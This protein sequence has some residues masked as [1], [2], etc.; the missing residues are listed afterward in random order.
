VSVLLTS[1]FL[2]LGIVV[3][4]WWAVALPLA[5][6]PLYYL[7][8]HLAGPGLE[9]DWW[10]GFLVV[11]ATSAALAA[12]GV[13]FRRLGWGHRGRRGAAGEGTAPR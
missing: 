2:A 3:G 13:L 11:T 8:L 7:G 10:L 12:L 5:V 1:A 9:G 4:R 6:W